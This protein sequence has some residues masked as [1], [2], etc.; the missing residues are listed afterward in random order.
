MT[1][2][3]D[4]PDLSLVGRIVTTSAGHEVRIIIDFDDGQVSYL[5]A[6]I[7]LEALIT[8]SVGGIGNM[9]VHCYNLMHGWRI[10]FALYANGGV[11]IRCLLT[12][13]EVLLTETWDYKWH[14]KC[15]SGL[16]YYRA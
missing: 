8:T 13:G 7:R 6:D 1:F 11:E 5:N 12:A 4:S 3:L 10:F 15:E 16:L 9:M 2:S 14:P